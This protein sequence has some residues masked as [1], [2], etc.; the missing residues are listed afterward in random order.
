MNCEWICDARVHASGLIP[1]IHF[2]KWRNGIRTELK[3][4]MDVEFGAEESNDV[5]LYYENS[6]VLEVCF[7]S[8]ILVLF[9]SGKL[10]NVFHTSGVVGLCLHA[11]LGIRSTPV[12]Q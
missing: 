12:P 4:D 3:L 6:G 2:R 8:L 11:N 5:G 9:V 10:S 7:C 1:G